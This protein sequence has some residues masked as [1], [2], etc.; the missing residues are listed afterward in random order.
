M[1]WWFLEQMIIFGFTLLNSACRLVTVISL[2]STLIWK[3]EARLLAHSD[4]EHIFWRL[5]VC[6]MLHR[7]T[8]I[9][10]LCLCAFGKTADYSGTADRL[11]DRSFFGLEW[12]V[13]FFYRVA[14]QEISPHVVSVS[15]SL[16][17]SRVWVCMILPEQTSA[18]VWVVFMMWT[19]MVPSETIRWYRSLMCLQGGSVSLS[20]ILWCCLGLDT[21]S[22]RVCFLWISYCRRASLR[23]QAW[24]A[25]AA[26]FL[27]MT[28][29]L[30]IV[31]LNIGCW[32]S[33]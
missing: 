15:V 30:V 14:F 12:E 25:S 10:V 5:P 2:H 28:F 32:R 26:I 13:K 33:D 4:L 8:S 16:L 9:S 21:L 11:G 6:L 19:W 24:G 3:A 7:L 22:V 20:F 17:T 27:S 31:S 1:I 23:A 29:R 18:K